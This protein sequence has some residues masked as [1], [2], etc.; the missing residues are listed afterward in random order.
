MAEF[1]YALCAIASTMC[2]VL[3]LRAFRAQRTRLLFW[4]GCCFVGLALN[5]VLLLMDLYVVP[6]VDLFAARTS[7]ALAGM[8]ALLYGLVCDSDQRA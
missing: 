8:I 2:A 5:N 6:D 3:L 1:V 4:S 7:V